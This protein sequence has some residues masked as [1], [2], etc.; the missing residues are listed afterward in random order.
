MLDTDPR[1]RNSIPPAPRTLQNTVKPVTFTA[2]WAKTTHKFCRGSQCYNVDT[3]GQNVTWTAG[4]TS[5]G[6]SLSKMGPGMLTLAPP[7]YHYNSYN[8]PT[9]IGGGTLFRG[10]RLQALGTSGVF[11][12]GSYGATITNNGVLMVNTS[13]NQSFGG[14]I[15][16]GGTLQVGSSTTAVLDA[17]NTYTGA[18]IAA[19]GTIFFGARRKR[20]RLRPAGQRRLPTIRARSS[21]E[22]ATWSIRAS[23]RTTTRAASARPPTSATTPTPTVRT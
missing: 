22:A 11:S 23:T 15:S 14:V 18:T 20:R 21:W 5:S 9:N 19:G 17:A 12:N 4:L 10:F 3:N 7:Y 2:F 1:I 16:G 6:G 8:G 13:Y